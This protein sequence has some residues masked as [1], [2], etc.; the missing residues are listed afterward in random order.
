MGFRFG[1]QFGFVK[2]HGINWVSSGGVGPQLPGPAPRGGFRWLSPGG[3][4]PC[5]TLG[6]I[7]GALGAVRVKY[8][9]RNFSASRLLPNHPL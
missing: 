7:G 1:E 4:A 3:G 9:F 6:V 2:Q 8:Q 5:F